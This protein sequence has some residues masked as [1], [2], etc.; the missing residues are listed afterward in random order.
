MLRNH[1]RTTVN[2][3]LTLKPI[4]LREGIFDIIQFDERL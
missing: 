1:F 2:I 4:E 3:D